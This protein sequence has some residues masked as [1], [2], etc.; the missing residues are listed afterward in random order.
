MKERL[1]LLIL[2]FI[3]SSCIPVMA[4]TVAKAGIVVSEERSAGDVVDDTTIWTSIEAAFIERGFH[5]LFTR[6][7][8]Q[9]SEG[10]VLLTGEVNS[11]QDIRT[12]LE[13]CWSRSSVKEV[14]NEMSIS[15]ESSN[16]FNYQQYTIDSW[17]T[18]R[19]KSSV[20]ICPDVKYVN[21]SIVT[22][23]N[24]VYLFGIAISK[25]ELRRVSEIAAK[26]S[27]VKKVVSYVRVKDSSKRLRA[28]KSYKD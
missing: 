24:I 8:I 3:I 12:A 21:Y 26:I 15:N 25:D 7:K 20:F 1:L 28:L 4:G 2:S 16:K 10:R 5:T 22:E 19:I 13:L 18:G 17:I 11:A 6:I 27:G 14:L 23:N 9:V